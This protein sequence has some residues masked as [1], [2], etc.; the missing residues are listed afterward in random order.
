MHLRSDGTQVHAAYGFPRMGAGLILLLLGCWGITSLARSLPGLI[1]AL[2]QTCTACDLGA[3][4]P[5]LKPFGRQPDGL[6]AEASRAVAAV[7]DGTPIETAGSAG[8]VKRDGAWLDSGHL[9]DAIDP[10][11][12]GGPP[13]GAP[14]AL[15]GE[16]ISGPWRLAPVWT[17]AYPGMT[18]TWS[19]E[20]PVPPG[21]AGGRA[22]AGPGWHEHF[23]SNDRPPRDMGNPDGAP[24]G[25]TA[26]IGSLRS[27]SRVAVQRELERHFPRIGDMGVQPGGGTAGAETAGGELAAD[28]RDA[29]TGLPTEANTRFTI[30]PDA[31]IGDGVS[32]HA[33]LIHDS[34]P[35]AANAGLL[36]MNGV[37][38]LD[39]FR[40]IASYTF[41]TNV[42]PS[43]QYFHTANSANAVRFVW[44]GARQ[45]NAGLVAGVAFDPWPRP[46]SPVR[47]LNLRVAAQYVAY[48][49]FS[50]APRGAAGNNALVLSLWGALRF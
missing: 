26:W 13:G 29:L 31:V 44:P 32:A 22:T 47:F 7:A 37:I 45:T 39:T 5:P 1:R 28:T 17:P 48:T 40:A 21:G 49:E 23:L 3:F 46:G 41:G 15:A 11:R 25:G 33:T 27:Y 20:P 19:M 36:G 34:P 2:D 12:F 42:T 30:D 6:S 38:A 16:P 24:A 9:L 18:L 14:D 10:P 43:I 35:L 4:E 50:G 8:A